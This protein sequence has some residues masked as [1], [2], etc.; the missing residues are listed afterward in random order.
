MIARFKGLRI[1]LK[2]IINSGQQIFNVVAL[3]LVVVVIF[4]IFGVHLFKG[5]FYRC[6][7]DG[8][9]EL[10]LT[11]DRI[12]TMEDCLQLGYQW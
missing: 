5:T 12:D 7:I 8:D 6:I 9:S 11:D 3:S 4:A 10:A 1:A 2:T